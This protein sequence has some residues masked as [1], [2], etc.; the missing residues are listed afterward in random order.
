MSCSFEILPSNFPERVPYAKT[1][2]YGDIYAF[3]N[4]CAHRGALI[5][6]ERDVRFP[7]ATILL[8]ERLSRAADFAVR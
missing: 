1:G 6:M 5:A 4:R 3:E 7:E 8:E 2:A